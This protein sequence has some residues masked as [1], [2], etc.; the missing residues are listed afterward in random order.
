MLK[1]FRETDTFFVK[2]L[3]LAH[4]CCNTLLPLFQ[5]HHRRTWVGDVRRRVPMGETRNAG[6]GGGRSSGTGKKRTLHRHV[7]PPTEHVFVGALS[8]IKVGF[9]FFFLPFCFFSSLCSS[10]FFLFSFRT[11]IIQR[12]MLLPPLPSSQ[13]PS[14]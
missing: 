12:V 10:F 13:V 4:C 1:L 7:R 9:P 6:A 11:I 14:V 8:H 2:L 3:A 5:Q